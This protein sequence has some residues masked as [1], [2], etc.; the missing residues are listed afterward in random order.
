[1][2]IFAVFPATPVPATIVNIFEELLNGFDKTLCLLSVEKY[3]VL[4]I[5][6]KMPNESVSLYAIVAEVLVS[7]GNHRLIVQG[8]FTEVV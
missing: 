6:I 7:F 2:S 8:E 1:L 5:S 4:L 3:K